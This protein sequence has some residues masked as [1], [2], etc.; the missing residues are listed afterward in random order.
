MKLELPHELVESA[1]NWQSAIGTIPYPPDPLTLAL[2]PPELWASYY[3]KFEFVLH[4]GYTIGVDQIVAIEV[5]DIISLGI[6]DRIGDSC[7]G[8]LYASTA[9]DLRFA[10][11]WAA[12]GVWE[13][14][15]SNDYIMS[16]SQHLPPSSH[17]VRPAKLPEAHLLDL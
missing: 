5:G 12:M 2:M 17:I 9:D 8:H 14:D 4:D 15:E 6:I 16:L 11:S 7:T 13:V 10:C 1:V 3:P